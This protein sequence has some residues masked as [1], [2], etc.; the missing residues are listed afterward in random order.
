MEEKDRSFFV[1]EEK[2]SKREK[3]FSHN[4]RRRQRER[5][6]GGKTKAREKKGLAKKW[7][8]VSQGGEEK[9]RRNRKTFTLR[10]F[11]ADEKKELEKRENVTAL[12]NQTKKRLQ[13]ESRKKKSRENKP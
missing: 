9:K 10:G 13:E 1:P 5:A 6:G 12:P 4:T 8:C 3:G 11:V 2:K 7:P